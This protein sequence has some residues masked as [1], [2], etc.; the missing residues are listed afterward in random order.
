MI[1][2]GPA[3]FGAPAAA[4]AAEGAG[5]GLIWLARFDNH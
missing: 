5:S 1:A 4:A 3:R 2:F